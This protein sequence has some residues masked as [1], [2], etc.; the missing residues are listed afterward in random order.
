MENR[1]RK[2]TELLAPAGSFD[3]LKAVAEAGADAVYGAGKRFGAR[4]YADNFTEEELLEAIDY[5]HLRGKRFYLTVNTLVKETEIQGLLDYLQPFYQ[6]GLDGVIVQ[7]LGVLRKV[8]SYFPDLPLHASTQMTITGVYGAKMLME[9]GCSR[10]VTARELSLEEIAHIYQETGVEIES[11]VHGALCYC[12]S[13]Q[14]LLSSMI[15][16]R[17]GNRGRCAQPCRLPYQLTGTGDGNGGRSFGKSRE[18]Y[19]LSLKDLCAIDLIPELIQ[20]G[21]SSFKIEGR[22]KQAEYAAGVTRIYRKYMDQYEREPE[23]EYQVSEEEKKMLAKLGNRCGFTDGYYKRQNG[24]DMVTFL[25]PS[26]E[27]DTSSIQEQDKDENGTKEKIKGILRLYAE[28]PAS[29]VIEY[30]NHKV[31]VTGELVQKSLKQPLTKET[32]LDKMGKIGNTP[33]VW[34]ELKLELEE[35]IFLPV[36]ALNHLR[37]TGLERLQEEILTKYR[38]SVPELSA[39]TA[40]GEALSTILETAGNVPLRSTGTLLSGSNLSSKFHQPELRVLTETLE[41]FQIVLS[42]PEVRRIYLEEFQWRGYQNFFEEG[43]RERVSQTHQKQKECYLAFPYVFRRERADWFAEHWKT[44][45]ASGLDGYLV[46]NLEELQFLKKMGAAPS[47]IQGDYNI[48]AYSKE[49]LRELEELS[50][51][52]VTLPVELN[53]K[54][55]RKINW[56]KGELILYGY[57]PLMISSQCVG[58]NTGRCDGRK[59]SFY[60]KDRYGK[61]FPVKCRCEDCYNVIY[62]ISPLSLLH[63]FQEVRSLKTEGVRLSFSIENAEETEQI[64]KYYR[65]AVSGGICREKYLSDYTN[66]HFKRGVE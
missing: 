26:H 52:H 60:L 8:R 15:G 37:R 25:K 34:E 41:Q 18:Q 54:E 46:R 21:V 43:L 64:F 17:S 42:Q 1:I 3:I 57:Q 19:L 2:K 48:Y 35:Q 7:D 5:L 59:R 38:R 20:S 33:F 51:Y 31:K 13:G 65:Q 28:T 32:I 40:S 50:L 29:L 24:K 49:A 16:G 56:A 6:G 62:N 30:K 23:K 14:C 66:G 22:M 44:I 45:E 58:K 55:L 4:A 12:Y 63:H 47:Q 53:L 10:I 36:K 11:F 27:K 39:N 61:G 9:A